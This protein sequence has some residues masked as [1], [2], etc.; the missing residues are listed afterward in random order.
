MNK[1]SDDPS[2]KQSDGQEPERR[3][4][5]VEEVYEMVRVFLVRSLQKLVEEHNEHEHTEEEKHTEYVHEFVRPLEQESY[6]RLANTDEGQETDIAFDKRLQNCWSVKPESSKS[7]TEAILFENPKQKAQKQAEHKDKRERAYEEI[8]QSSEKR[9][10]GSF[11]SYDLLSCELF[12]I[13][14]Q[15][16]ILFYCN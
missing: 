10:I 6:F 1:R 16:F 12:I 2:Q 3:F 13:A 14:K 5:S 9:L 4:D 7:Q 15:Q 11:N 8:Q